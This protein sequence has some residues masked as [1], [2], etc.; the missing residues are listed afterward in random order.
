VS[1]PRF[2]VVIPTRERPGTLRYALETCLTQD[3]DDYEVV[4]CDNHGSPATR[5]VVDQLASGRIRY[6]RAPRPLAMSDNWELAVAEAAGEYVTILGDDDGLARHAL[7][8]LD[9]L[10]RRLDARVLRW[11]AAFYTWPTLPFPEERDYL[12]LPL[13]RQVREVDARAVMAGVSRF[14]LPYVKL[15]MLYNSLI[16]ASVLDELRAR[17]GRVFGNR[18][19]DVYSGFALAWVAGR[20]WSVDAPMSVAG[21][22]S[23]SYGIAAILMRGR[24]PRGREIG[25]MDDAA[26]LRPHPRVPDLPIFPWVAVADAFETARDALFPDDPDLVLDRKL[27]VERCLQ[28]LRVDGEEERRAAADAVRA[29]CGDDPA[30]RDW[31]EGLLATASVGTAPPLRLRPARLGHYDGCL[32]LDAAA[33]GVR[34]VAGAVALTESLLRLGAAP[35]DYR[36]TP[37]PTRPPAGARASAPADADAEAVAELQREELFLFRVLARLLDT[38][39]M[40]DVGAH[41]GTT[42]EPFLAAGW[43][44]FGF[45]PVAANR[46]ALAARFPDHPRLVLRPE[47]VS[48]ASGRRTLHLAVTPEGAA[49]DAHHSLEA[50]TRDAWHR[51]GALAE[52][53]TVALD[54]LVHRGELPP[55][56]GVLKIDAEGHDL[57][58]LRGA[59]ALDAEAVCV[60]FWC[61]AH[62]FGPSP[63]PLDELVRVLAARGYGAYLVIAHHLDGAV[64]VLH[65][66]LDAVPA[67]GWGNLVAFRRG[68]RAI[69]EGVVAELRR[70]A[71]LRGQL[72]AKEGAIQRLS[73]EAADL[74]AQLVAKEARIQD[75][76]AAAAELQVRL[77]ARDAAV[78]PPPPA[79]GRRAAVLGRARRLAGAARRLLRALP[80]PGRGAG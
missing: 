3:F 45:E 58:V 1:R 35:E 69:D 42:L 29:A 57:A 38:R 14:A 43:Q 71:G 7:R 31:C 12:R 40:V 24:S 47:A 5:E 78:A 67:D 16:H 54:D 77:L 37:L 34:D 19:P 15:P 44:V 76:S 6:V 65:S 56:V 64:E 53:D 8:D 74:R 59:A 49:A 9:R 63:A 66:T 70:V 46:R 32:H 10:A 61:D 27:L 33:L 68:V 11:E 30:L 21:L 13:G 28:S 79:P 39:I 22:S 50:V 60:E 62:P 23:E 80:R 17:A 55:Q 18:Y 36:V 51:A 72:L 48:S 75:L 73:T 2:S 4:V 26:G 20:Y 25:P 52:V 41:R